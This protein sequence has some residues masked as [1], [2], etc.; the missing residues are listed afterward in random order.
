VPIRW[1]GRFQALRREGR[2]GHSIASMRVTKD[3]HGSVR[4][5]AP[6]DGY[7]GTIHVS[8]EVWISA[9]TVDE[10]DPEMVKRRRVAAWVSEHP[11]SPARRSSR[12]R[13]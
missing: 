7:I 4:E 3:R 11:G 1:E 5:F 6:K 13:T 2:G 8:N 10:V 12:V 9:P